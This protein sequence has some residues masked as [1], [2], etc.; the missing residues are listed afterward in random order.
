M[1]WIRPP[2]AA[3]AEPYWQSLRSG[4]LAIQRCTACGRYRH[5]P[6]P[7]CPHCRSF[8]HEWAA[9]SGRATLH[10][11]TVVHHPVH[12]ILTA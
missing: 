10:T 1:S 7:I 6:S 2:D 11:F 5:P 4:V 9:V 3:L 12:P 8:D